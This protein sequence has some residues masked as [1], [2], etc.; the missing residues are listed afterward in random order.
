MNDYNFEEIE[1]GLSFEFCKT[2]TVEMMDAF[3]DISDDSNPLHCDDCFAKE[4]G[5]SGRVVYGMLTSSLY[6][7]LV[8]VYLP[9]KHCLLRSVF[10]KL[11]SPVYIGDVLT[12]N[13][14][15]N[16]KHI[17]Y[18]LLSIKADIKNQDGI[19]VS[20]AMIQV[21]FSSDYK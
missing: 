9:G 8:G 6:S 10:T 5:F 14:V 4:K 7:T 15:V 20:K 3:F 21:A 12:V 2:I 1:I 11:L 13:G 17:E 16:E 18:R 19:R